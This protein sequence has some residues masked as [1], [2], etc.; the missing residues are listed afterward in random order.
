MKKKNIQTIARRTTYSTA[1]YWSL[2]YTEAYDDGSERD[3]KAIIKA[4]SFA[5]AQEILKQKVAEDSPLA[6]IKSLQGFLL[7]ANYRGLGGKSLRIKD[8]EDIRCAAFPNENNV[9]FKTEIERSP[10][11]TNRFNATDLEQLK[12]I[13][14]K[15]GAENWS[16][17]HRRGKS[18]PSSERVGKIYIGKWVTWDA[19]SRV[20]V[21]NQLIYSLIK[22]DHN[23]SRAAKEMGVSR[24]KVYDL[25]RRFPEIDWDKEYPPYPKKNKNE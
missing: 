3:F 17:K 11:K 22:H 18:L 4:R 12:S 23:R 10:E 2:H 6:T 8:W 24:N 1:Q 7:H 15:S 13:G 9:L 16:R 14:F 5:L 19:L 20:K 21:R 25:F